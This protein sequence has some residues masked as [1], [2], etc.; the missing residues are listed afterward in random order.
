MTLFCSIV[1]CHSVHFAVTLATPPDHFTLASCHVCL[2]THLQFLRM[3]LWEWNQFSCSAAQWLKKLEIDISPKK[4]LEYV[5]MRLM[6]EAADWADTYL[7]ASRFL[8][9]QE[10]TIQSA[11]AFTICFNKGF[12]QIFGHC[13]YLLI[14][15]R[16]FHRHLFN[17]LHSFSL[18]R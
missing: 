4:L 11:V 14:A 2:S 17:Q 10:P 1:Y 8:R 15:L 3:L 12:R 5:G 9:E 18:L 6:D 7:D 16:Y 13:L